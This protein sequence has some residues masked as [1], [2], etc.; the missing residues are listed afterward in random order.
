KAGLKS[1]EHLLGLIDAAAADESVPNMDLSFLDPLAREFVTE[2]GRGEHDLHALVD[3][4]EILEVATVSKEEGA[5]FTPTLY[6]MSNMT[7]NPAPPNPM[8]D[9]YMSI[10]MQDLWDF[11]SGPAYAMSED[12]MRGEDAVYELRSLLMRKLLGAGANLLVGTDSPVT[13]VPFGFA[14]VEELRAMVKAGV[15]QDESLRAATLNP[16]RYF[17]R[18]GEL[19]EIKTGALADLILLE[20]NPLED[21]GALR[22]IAGVMSQGQWRARDE[23]QGML[24]DI[25]KKNKSIELVFSD[26]PEFP[27]PGAALAD[28]L[29]EDGSATRV[30]ADHSD[31][32]KTTI[33]AAFGESD[34][35]KSVTID[36]GEEKHL[37]QSEGG[38]TVSLIY[39]NGQ[40]TL[41]SDGSVIE[42]V[43]GEPIASVL[44]GTPADA[45]ILRAVVGDLEPGEERNA[46]VWNCG[47]SLDCSSALSEIIRIRAVKREVIP[48]YGF[49]LEADV[50]EVAAVQ[51][52]NITPFS[53]WIAQ[54]FAKGQPVRYEVDGEKPWRRIR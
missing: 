14:M 30:I 47:P 17:G 16:A 39:Q 33:R 12:Q 3:D 11:A 4:Q 51:R 54:G 23:L 52:G 34:A 37:L 50:Y 38:T 24:D 13:H 41:T 29:A 5:W 7:S 10:A 46:F 28:F 36:V 8:W 53:F 21:V 19:G 32:D 48:G 25:V 1:T 26:A 18:E 35:W 6:A 15:P 49:F 42:S 9:K 2:L 31:D 45:A 44:T 20:D 40:W 22:E 27:D 43:K